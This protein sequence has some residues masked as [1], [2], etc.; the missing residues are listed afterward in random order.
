MDSSLALALTVGLPAMTAAVQLLLARHVGRFGAWAMFAAAVSAFGLCLGLFQSEEVAA[1]SVPWIAE[2]GIF[3]SLRADRF[4]LF[5]AMLVSG[6]GAL[7]AAYSFAYVAD[8]PPARL[9]R[10]Y[11]ALT[12][13][14][15]AM[16]GLAVS[17]DL[18]TLALFWEATSVT[19]WMLI[20]FWYEDDNA[21]RG[22]NVALQVTAL[23]GLV[24]L[25]GFL[26]LGG[27]AG[28]F[29]LHQLATHAPA[30][31]ALQT[32]GWIDAALALILVGV[33]TKSAQVPFHFWLPG[34]MV[35][36]TPVSTYLHAATMVKAGIF[37]LGRLWPIFADSPLWMPVLTAV[38]LATFLVGAWQALQQDDLKA[39]LAR[40][41]VS[42]LG[43]FT[44]MY[45]LGLAAQD[46]LQLLAHATYKGCL[47]LCAGV[48][49][50]HTGTRDLRLLGGLRRELPITFV[51]AFVG[52][53]G[54]CG[55]PPAIG[56][57]SKELLYGGLLETH[58]LPEGFRMAIVGAAVIG[59]AL[60]AA[61]GLRLLVG[62][63]LGE[64]AAR[65]HGAPHGSHGASDGANALHDAHHDVAGA[66]GE[67]AL[68]WAPPLVLSVLSVALFALS[69]TPVTEHLLRAT[70]STTAEP[71][72]VALTALHAGPLALSVATLVL[73][74][75]IYAGRDAIVARV[76]GAAD[77]PF[78]QRLWESGVKKLLVFGDAFSQRWQNGSLHWYFSATL[79]FAAALPLLA[80]SR[81][82]LAE[83]AVAISL[84]NVDPYGVVVCLMAATASIAV[85]T[86]KT[87]LAA[88][89][90]LTAVGFLVAAIFVVYR[91][92]DIVLTQI[93]IE[94]VSTILVLLV[95]FR[96]PP[97]RPEPIAPQRRAWNLLVSVAV[98]VSVFA[99]L[100]L[101]SSPSLRSARTIA[102]EYLTR[103]LP[104][105]GG[106]NVVNVIIV[107]FRALD[108]TGEIT[109]LVVVALCV[110][111]VLHS[112]R[113]AA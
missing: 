24:M 11:A 44:M 40:T 78:S 90:A 97:F 22:A 3:F 101:A 105:A 72:H 83:D 18:L 68:L 82:D 86:A 67:R 14:M 39:L 79:L 16:L 47:F 60:L 106:T 109:V 32:S 103:S 81:T 29:S 19:S 34:A 94:T 15:T 26:V 37:L 65:G 54:I 104:E 33:L 88:A 64:R 84:A 76:V 102:T 35:A 48:I 56:F 2:L 30:A 49:E 7:V 89:I 9:G 93:L 6:V 50:H 71:V 73:A 75:A 21:R 100:L 98:S 38:G 17:D 4:G 46:S 51:A 95:L 70:S 27:A 96:M 99:T 1:F 13:F 61:A 25:V 110:W 77:V 28:T 31:A 43:M 5:F 55:L 69:A 10:F 85:A 108:T 74:L 113:S 8:L 42:A 23:G 12:A 80:L 63:F 91:S 52:V 92:P 66:H 36:P 111:G 112:R 58:A 45:G 53:L 59:N 107:D 57:H 87:R 41:T 62:S 20:G